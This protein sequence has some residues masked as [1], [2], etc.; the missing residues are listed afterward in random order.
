[1]AHT[2]G[3]TG[4]IP[5]LRFLPLLAILAFAA[6]GESEEHGA[7]QTPAASAPPAVTVSEPVR[8]RL[9]EWD[10]Y[11]GRFAAVERV[12]IRPRVAGT[13]D[14]VHFTDGALV[15]AGDRLFTI[16]PRPYEATVASA[17]AGLAQSRA[18]LAFARGE[19]DRAR[20]LRR[21]DAVP[22]RT[23]DQRQQ[24]LLVA[25]AEILSAEAAVQR[26]R[27]DLEFTEIRSPVSGRVG[28][29]VIRPGN[30]V[31]GGAGAGEATLLTTVVSMDPIHLYF[32]ADQTAYLRYQRL[33]REGFRPSSREQGNPVQAA[34][35]DEQGWPHQGRM[36]FVDN[37][38]DGGTGT[39]RGRAVFPNPD[40]LL[41]PGMFARMRL[42][43]SSEYEAMLV[44]QAAIG[45]DQGRRFAYV[46]EG[47]GTAR[48]REV[49]LGP[50]VDGLQ[51]VR[52]GLRAEDRVVVNGLQRVRPG[53]RV[54][55]EH[56]P[57]EDHA[58]R[59]AV[60]A[61]SGG[62]GLTRPAAAEGAR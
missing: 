40:M 16:D 36:D 51:L 53:T 10:E 14:A 6:C 23:F 42:V 17:D 54:T 9:T 56:K 27:L 50:V 11:T 5:R 59:P 57:L 60:A 19:V 18:R 41:T 26:A 62:G 2:T 30:L 52:E 22:A 15:R 13:L 47:D 20:E 8:R 4:A 37:E 1:M 46:V 61:G 25:Q 34:L 43:G 49:R 32:D 3:P 55:P 24:E 28:R 33:A 35:S 48:Q 21:S 58:A 29:A 45:T 44:P 12:E 31:A 38:I 7:A 39:I